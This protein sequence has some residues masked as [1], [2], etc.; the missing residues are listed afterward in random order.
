[1]Y[2]NLYLIVGTKIGKRNESEKRND[3]FKVKTESG[4]NRFPLVFG[5]FQSI[6][7]RLFINL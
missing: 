3:E 6:K 2:L 7:E 4:L 1:M 5:F